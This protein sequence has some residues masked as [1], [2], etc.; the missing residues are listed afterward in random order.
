LFFIVATIFVSTITTSMTRLQIISSKQ[1]SQFAQLRRFLLDKGISRQ[2]AMKVL[3]N[4]Q[5]AVSE[6]KHN[7]PESSVELLEIISTPLRAE[8]HFEVH[9]RVICSHPFLDAFAD[10]NPPAARKFCHTAV[11]TLTLSIGDNLFNDCETPVRPRMFFIVTGSLEYFRR[12]QSSPSSPPGCSR[13]SVL[14][15][16]TSC[17]RSSISGAKAGRISSKRAYEVGPGQSVCEAVLWTNWTHCGTLKALSE[18]GITELD[19]KLFQEACST[20]PSM[21]PG[22]YATKF[23]EHLNELADRDRSLLSDLP[24]GDYQISRMLECAFPQWEGTEDVDD[25]ATLNYSL[26][27]MRR[28]SQSRMSH[29]SGASVGDRR[30]SRRVSTIS[31]RRSCTSSRVSTTASSRGTPSGMKRASLDGI[32]SSWQVMTGQGKLGQFNWPRNSEAV[33]PEA[34]DKIAEDESDK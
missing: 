5:H 31:A 14:T 32:R 12:T 27:F 22:L 10:E 9:S 25:M 13:S 28:S 24:P 4:A 8:L 19:A 1:S 16:S 2:L 7:A 18:C 11:S 17:G 3:R 6:Q 30:S 20:F 29:F 33:L 15:K 26:A 34:T 23:V 21:H